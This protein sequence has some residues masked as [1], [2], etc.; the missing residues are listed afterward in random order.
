MA[1]IN[2]PKKQF[3]FNVIAPGLN[4]Y[5]VQ[6]ANIPDHEIE[7]VEHGDVNYTVK[8]PGRISFGNVIL[9]KLRPL[10]YTDNWIWDWIDQTQNAFTGGGGIPDNIK[11]NITIVQLASDNITV[12][13]QWEI[14][15]A[16]PTRLND[17]NLSRVTSDNSLEKIELSVDRVRK[18]R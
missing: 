5:A 17:M 15:G 12:T 16:W 8:T 4:P 6:V 11:R 14:E 9:E 7:Q 10:D 1:K 13:D 2:N 18:V 3:N